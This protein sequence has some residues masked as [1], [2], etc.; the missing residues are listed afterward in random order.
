M[1]VTERM[2]CTGVLLECYKPWPSFHPKKEVGFKAKICEDAI[3]RTLSLYAARRVK[4]SCK[5]EY[6]MHRRNWNERYT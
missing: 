4:E 1:T 5:K 3:N 6:A 2:K